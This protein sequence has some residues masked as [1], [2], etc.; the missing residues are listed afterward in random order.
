[1]IAST[2]SQMTQILLQKGENQSVRENRHWGYKRTDN[3]LFAISSGLFVLQNLEKYFSKEEKVLLRNLETEVLKLYPS[4]K[5]KDGKP[6]YNFYPTKPSRHFGGG[7]FMRHFDHFRLPDDIDDTALVFLTDKNLKNQISELQILLQKH[8]HSMGFWNT[9]FGKNMP[10][11]SDICAQI[12]MLILYFSNDLENDVLAQNTLSYIVKAI[13]NFEKYPF[14]Y[15][16]HYGSASL[17]LYHFARFMALF[18]SSPLEIHKKQL[19]DI[20]KNNLLKEKKLGEILIYEIT[21]LKLGEKREKQKFPEKMPRF[22][23]FIGA[24]FAPLRFWNKLAGIQ[25]LLINWRSHFYQKALI[26]EYEILWENS[27]QKLPLGKK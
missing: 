18:P 14:L 23:T 22:Y 15:A 2:I 26:L 8:Q 1:M 5:N 13:P 3:S 16:R 7:Y 19:K 25:L 11:E 6:T 24:P 20:C 12:N 21:L 10:E 27:N 9:W 4:Y 17:I